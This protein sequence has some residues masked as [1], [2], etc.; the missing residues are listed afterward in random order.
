MEDDNNQFDT[1]ELKQ[2]TSNAVNQV[3][4]TM[5]D[6]KLK[7]ETTNA[8]NFVKEMVKDPISKTE[9]IAHDNENKYLKTSIFMVLAWVLV[10]VLYSVLSYSKYST[11][12]HN[13]LSTVKSALSPIC[14]ILG[15]TFIIFMFNKKNKK[16]LLSI[17][18]TVTT[19]YIPMIISSI[20][21][22]LTLID[23]SMYRITNA[24]AMLASIITIILSYFAIKDIFEEDTELANLKKFVIVEL[25]YLGVAIVISFLGI[26]MYI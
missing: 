11:L 14:I 18:S 3:R 6:I 1:D 9:E 5:K 4:D 19:V 24:V 21:H 7:D 23:Y 22:L 17:F 10:K 20:I 8:T 26:S 12:G 25:V 13:I 15:L 2:E 16:P